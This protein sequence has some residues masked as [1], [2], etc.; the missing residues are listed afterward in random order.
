MILNQYNKI[1][2]TFCGMMGSG[3]TIIGKR[4]A[5]L[6]N[7]NF[8]DTDTIIEEKTGKSI[9]QIF[10][11]FGEIYF[12]DLEEK[13]ITKILDKKNYVFSLGGGVMMNK[14]LRSII[15]KKSFNIYLQV[16]NDTLTKRLTK[17]KKRPL[18]YKKNIKEKIFELMK[19]REKFYKQANLIINNEKEIA[20]T[21][22][23][24]KKK[25]KI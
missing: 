12:R 10:I 4:F 7:C 19:E 22:N 20:D 14:K 1:N 15:Q 13:I 21:I 9:N 2:I 25:F 18:I 17:S 8:I 23:N 3:K 16:D 11:E 6:I 24:L 5:K